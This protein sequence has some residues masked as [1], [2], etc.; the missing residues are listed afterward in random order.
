MFTTLFR[1][2]GGGIIFLKADFYIKFANLK[3]TDANVVTVRFFFLLIKQLGH[4]KKTNDN[5]FYFI[6]SSIQV[7]KFTNQIV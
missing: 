4:V 2:E 6:Y 3:S 7:P 1:A 5:Y